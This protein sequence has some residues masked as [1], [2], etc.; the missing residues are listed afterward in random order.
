MLQLLEEALAGDGRHADD[1]SPGRNPAAADLGCR[2]DHGAIADLD[3][4]GNSGTSR[5][6]HAIADTAAAGDPN[7]ASDQAVLAD[8]VVV[9][10]HDEIIDLG[11]IAHGRGLDRA[12]IDAAVGADLDVLTEHHRSQRGDALD[13]VL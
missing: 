12:A 10:D 1:D 13:R 8:L 11:P 3:M 4:V 5:H 7:A 9:A 2:Q 6:D